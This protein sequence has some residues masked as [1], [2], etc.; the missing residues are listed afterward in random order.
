M[1]KINK[2]PVARKLSVEFLNVGGTFAFQAKALL[3][4]K[5]RFQGEHAAPFLLWYVHPEQ[6][7][8]TSSTPNYVQFLACIRA[9][10]SHA[11]QQCTT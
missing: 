4:A 7:S 6:Y 8:Y 3:A 2:S 1:D 11:L 10:L 9:R 5:P